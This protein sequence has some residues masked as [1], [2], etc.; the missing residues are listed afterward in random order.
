MEF[1]HKLADV[2]S[3]SQK[4]FVSLLAFKALYQAKTLTVPVILTGIGAVV[5]DS[6]SSKF[7]I[8]L[9]TL[10]L[11]DNMFLGSGLR[12]WATEGTGGG[13]EVQ[14]FAA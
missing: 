5:S 11:A 2:S 13:K 1:W 3:F 4:I 14:V 6:I 7:S 8:F 10:T 9:P 12:G